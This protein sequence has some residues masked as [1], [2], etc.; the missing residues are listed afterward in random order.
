MPLALIALAAGCFGIGLTEFVIAGLLPEVAADFS[1]SA[2]AAGW[3]LTAYALSVAVGAILVTAVATRFSRKRALIAMMVIFIVGNLLSAV[4]PAYGVLLAG[5]VVSALC[6]GAFFGIAAVVAVSLVEPTRR[7]GAVAA[8]FTG[9]AAA[10]VLGVPFGTL[11][12]QA[13]GWRATFWSI[14]VIGVIALVGIVALVPAHH[15]GDAPGVLREEVQAFRS[16]QV[17]LTLAATALGLGA[18]F[19]PFTYI[20]FTLT[21]VSGFPTAAVPWLLVLFGVGLVLGNVVGG[22]LANRTVDGTLRW[23][24]AGLT[25]ALALFAL[26]AGSPLLACVLLLLIGACSFGSLPAMQSRLMRFAGESGALASSA[27]TAAANVGNAVAAWAGGLVITAGLGY[28]APAWV[29][30]VMAFAALV[31][32]LLAARPSPSAPQ[33]PPVA[34]A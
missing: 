6:H 30:A 3:L 26:T 25:A 17:W 13:F 2:G 19:A 15:D 9:L 33:A 31:V 11:V 32:V 8:V 16:G 34:A 10:N 18:L 23:M 12:G 20:A 5:R 22:R 21:R 14:T 7:A 24:L 29:G 4:A 28:T 27:A 1:V